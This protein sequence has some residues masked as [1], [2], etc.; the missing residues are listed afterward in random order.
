[1]AGKNDANEHIQN[2][3]L[4]RIEQ[5][6]Y[7]LD[8]EYDD[9]G[10][11]GDKYYK[12]TIGVTVLDDKSIADIVLKADKKTAPFIL[13]KPLHHSQKVLKQFADGSVVVQIR[14]HLNFELDRLI[15]GFG[16]GI[17]VLQPAFYR[18]RIKQ[19]LLNALEN[20]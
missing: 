15:L 11:N 13:T 1:V 20:Y 8:A 10:F 4:D 16:K 14:V 9:I 6:D 5:L 12:N 17:E 18:G 3:A 7:E 19:L 2:F